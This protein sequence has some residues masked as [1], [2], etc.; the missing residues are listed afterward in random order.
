[1][2]HEKTQTD[3]IFCYKDGDFVYISFGSGV[4]ANMRKETALELARAIIQTAN[5]TNKG[6]N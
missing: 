6:L 1:M 2:D 5:T 4:S 3:S